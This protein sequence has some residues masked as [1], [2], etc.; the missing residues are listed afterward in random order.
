MV[1]PFAIAW[2]WRGFKG[3]SV[4]FALL[5]ACLVLGWSVTGSLWFFLRDLG[6]HWLF[7]LLVPGLFFSWLAKREERLIPDE[8][9]RKL[10]ARGLIVAS[11]L[12]ALLVALIRR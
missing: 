9:Q 1:N 12:L 3:K 5:F 6:V 7:A 4:T 11:L 10:W 8:K 2:L